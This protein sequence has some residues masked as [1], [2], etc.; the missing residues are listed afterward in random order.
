MQPGQGQTV[1]VAGVE[2]G[3]IGQVEL[4]D[5]HA[6]VEL[7]LEPKYEGFIKDDA[8]ALLRAKTGL[9]DMFLEVDPG[10][11][12]PLREAATGSRC[13]NTAPDL[14]PDE[15][16]SALDSDTRD[17]LQA[18]DLRRRQGPRRARQGPARGVR[19]PRAAAPRPGQRQ[20]APSPGGGTTSTRLVNRYGL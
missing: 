15:F 5:G 7:E 4:E 11:G 14:D 9:K 1:R 17:Y 3:Q 6:V 19:A 10:D 2:I 13:E 8:S 16:L 20:Q 12:E 18:A